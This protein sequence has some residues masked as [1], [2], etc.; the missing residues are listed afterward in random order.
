VE[1]RA[2][3]LAARIIQGE[4]IRK[5][6]KAPERHHTFERL[7]RKRCD[8]LLTV[9]RYIIDIHIEIVLLILRTLLSEESIK[10]SSEHE[11]GTVQ[12]RFNRGNGEVEDLAY[13][14]ARESIN[15]TK[16][17]YGTVIVRKF[18]NRGLKCLKHLI[19]D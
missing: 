2:F 18:P 8:F 15:I 13:L 10:S 7:F 11:T 19:A 3:D 17:K 6:K 4:R 14:S 16:D 12:S 9:H 1:T 5:I